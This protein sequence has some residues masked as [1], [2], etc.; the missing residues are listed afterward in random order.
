[1]KKS[2]YG[3]NDG[4]GGGKRR[5]KNGKQS[6]T[7]MESGK[8]GGQAYAYIKMGKNFNTNFKSVRG[9]KNKRKGS[10]GGNKRY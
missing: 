9:K 10:G 8:A 2:G 6:N 7:G 1:M 4:R 3:A 5:K